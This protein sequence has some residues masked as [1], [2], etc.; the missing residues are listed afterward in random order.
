MAKLSKDLEAGNLHPRESLVIAGTLGALNAE[1]ITSCD[2]CATVALD[3]RGTFSMTVE[4][5]GTVDGTNWV[6]IPVRPQTGGA[7]VAA[8]VG[9]TSG[10]W[11]ASCAGF[12]KVRARCT[13]YT[14]GGSTATLMA[15]NAMFDDFAKN[16][17]VTS[18]TGTAVGASGAAV[19]LTLAAPGAGLRH[20]ITY[21][22]INRYAAA[23]LTASATPVTITTTNIPTS[24]AFT[25][26]ADAAALGTLDRW[27]EDFAYP[28]MVTAQN[29]AT[30][31]VAPVTTGVI[32]RITAGYYLA[33]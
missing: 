25:I 2:G 1:V 21:L 8:V 27:R 11:M 26:P 16:G 23:V 33:P 19:T 28:I 7:Y 32:W 29:T 10:V 9:T 30:T 22:S 5:A 20:Y 17:G 15:S 14:S 13:A 3:L 4:V 24:L 31:I 12:D 18:V 6:V